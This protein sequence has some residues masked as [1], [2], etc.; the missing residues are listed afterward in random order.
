M[1]WEGRQLRDLTE[2]DIHQVIGSGLAE[3]LQL[4]YK[5]ELYQNNDPGNK[6]SLLD[7][8]M[9]ANADGGI[10]LLG[11]SELRDAQ[12]QP[13][14]IPDPARPLGL[15]V[16]NPEATLQAIDARVTA[17]IQERLRLE[18][19]AIPLAGGSHVLVFRIPNSTAKPHCVRYRGHVYFPSRRERSRYDMDVRE[20]KELAMKTASQLEKS[21]QMLRDAM[22]GVAVGGPCVHLGAVPL[23]GKEFLIDIKDNN[24]RRA[25][26]AFDM[27]NDRPQIGNVCYTFAGLERRGGNST[28]EVHR[29][30]MV[31]VRNQLPT[32]EV[33]GITSFVPTAI[34]LQ[35]RRFV[36]RL[37]ELYQVYELNG[38]Y[39]FTMLLRTRVPLAGLYPGPVP[40]AQDLS[41][42]VLP[43]EYPFPVMALDNLSSIDDII[44][45]FCD[46]AHQTFGH[47][48]SPC[49]GVD[50]RWVGLAR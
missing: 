41:E 7:I 3:H 4:E 42:P 26:S 2:A 27:L 8:C 16:D 18:S 47:G 32:L 45:P 21:Q 11:V 49:F 31:V 35:T 39:L 10:L 37:K 36:V 44:R 48:A 22:S 38:P 29:N 13:T 12:G 6:E 5:S 20:I 15:N 33:G 46:H 40:G 19:A 50:G 43:G 14:G 25:V 17:A 28:I 23:F 30:G 24:I 34:D 1:L 9:F